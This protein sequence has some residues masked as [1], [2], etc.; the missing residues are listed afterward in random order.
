MRVIGVRKRGKVVHER[1]YCD[2]EYIRVQ[3]KG[4]EEG[5]SIY[6]ICI[7]M[8]NSEVVVTKARDTWS[9]EYRD[10]RRR[11]IDIEEVQSVN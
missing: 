3:N 4:R 11:F 7:Y 10:T 1:V 9:I 8:Y 5:T 2:K 6:N